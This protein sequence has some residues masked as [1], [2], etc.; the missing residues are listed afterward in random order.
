M[1]HTVGF[2]VPQNVFRPKRSRLHTLRPVSL[3]QGVGT[4]II[5]LDVYVSV[6]PIPGVGMRWEL[7][8]GA[9]GK[10][11][12]A[13]MKKLAAIAGGHIPNLN[14]WSSVLRIWD[15]RIG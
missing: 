10:T 3:R 7:A 15:D 6:D 13:L 4:E 5:G 1:V 9:G 2:R 11:R 12:Q 14:S 8:E